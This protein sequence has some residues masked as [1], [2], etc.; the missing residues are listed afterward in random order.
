M[1]LIKLNFISNLLVEWGVKSM[2]L[3]EGRASYK[4]LETSDSLPT[5]SEH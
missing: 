4:S 1:L 5:T 2:K 3:S